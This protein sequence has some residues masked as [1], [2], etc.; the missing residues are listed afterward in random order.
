MSIMRKDN[1]QE[2]IIKRSKATVYAAFR[3][4]AATCGRIQGGSEA[5]GT[6][7]CRAS[8]GMLTNTSTVRISV[9]EVDAA[10]TRVQIRSESLDGWVGFGSAGKAIDRLVDVADSIIHGH[11]PPSAGVMSGV[12]GAV[13][14][15]VGLFLVLLVLLALQFV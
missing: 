12:L 13:L 9:S 3:Q 10:T 11:A 4:A 5:M 1:E 2:V 14:L 7:V 6:I 8:G 15:G